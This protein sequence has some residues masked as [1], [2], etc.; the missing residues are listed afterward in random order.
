LRPAR[1]AL[2]IALALGA[3][4]AVGAADEAPPTLA[5]HTYLILP[6]EN[7]AEEPSLDW[8]STGLSLSL[9]EYLI[10][11]GAG[12]V[13]DEER[14]VLLEGNSIPSGAP[15]ALASVLEL[16]RKMR[17][18]PGAVRPDRIVLGRFNVQEGG[19]TVHARTFDLV[20]EKGRPWTVRT[21]RLRD[22]LEVQQEIA[23]ALA[24][25]EGLRVPARSE[26]VE[27]H[28]GGLP[29]LAFETYCRAMATT[30]SKK[31]LQLLK[32][33]AQEFP[34]YPKAAYQAAALL[35]KEERWGEAGAM[36]GRAAWDPHPY[37]AD[38][39]LLAAA[40]ALHRR[41]ARTAAEEARSA[42]RHADTARG[43]LLLGRALLA[44]GER[45]EAL[46]AWRKARE[47][48]PSDPEVGE[49]G[50][51]LG[52]GQAERPRSGP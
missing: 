23:L 48:D 32:R 28:L 49:L 26:A 30:D 33:A 19:L 14:A 45:D 16:G 29:L 1:A 35:A 4:L 50:R 36:L 13:D 18:R 22:L 39:H 44:L 24:R 20:A 46:I 43:Q 52:E 38:A 40:V 10:G 42:L 31:R 8:L 11:F 9:G 37:T 27:R 12:S 15:L 34:G 51:A 6:F 25:D 47:A 7:V 2:A 41:D 17:S 21:G 5:G 3:A